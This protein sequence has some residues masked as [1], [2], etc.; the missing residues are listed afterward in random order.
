MLDACHAIE[1][2][3]NFPEPDEK[4]KNAEVPG[5]M[6]TNMVAQLK[7]FNALDIL[8]D[9]MKLIPSVRLDAGLPPL[10][11]PTSQIVGVQ[12]V[13]SILNLKN[14]R[15][16]YANPSNQFVAL[17]KGEYGKTPVPVKP[18]FREKITGSPVEVPYDTS[19]YK[20]QENPLL[21]GIW[22]CAAC[23]E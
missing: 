11:T 17:V 4:V 13:N 6:Y 21:P 12:A 15:D 5:G 18:E 8:E 16:K 3:F 10:V 14:G 9:A 20:R 22:K 2:Y 19:K 23:S 1:A 7:Q